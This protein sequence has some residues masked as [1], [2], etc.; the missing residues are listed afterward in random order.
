MDELFI[1]IYF[2]FLIWKSC[3]LVVSDYW[4][5]IVVLLC[6]GRFEER[7]FGFFCAGYRV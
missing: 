3:F 2:F 7:V 6:L 4:M 1:L 5:I